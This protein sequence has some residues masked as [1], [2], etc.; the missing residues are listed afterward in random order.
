LV[1]EERPTQFSHSALVVHLGVRQR[2]SGWVGERKR[3]RKREQG[4]SRKR[5]KKRRRRRRRRGGGGGGAGGEREWR[6]WRKGWWWRGVRDWQ[7]S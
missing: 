7:R 5:R 2:Q 1:V 4:L 3:E 6:R